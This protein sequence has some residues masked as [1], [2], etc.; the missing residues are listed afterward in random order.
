MTREEAQERIRTRELARLGALFAG[1]AHEIRNPLSTIGL[2][3]QL[4]KEDFAEPESPA[5]KR[6]L[7]RMTVIESEVKRLQSILDEFLGYVRVPDLTRTETDINEL[8]EELV[9][10]V[11][12]EMASKSVSL[13]YFGNSSVGALTVDSDQ[14]RAVFVN[15]LRNALDA[16]D[17]DDEVMVSLRTGTATVDIQITD[18]GHGMT[19][20]VAKKVFTPYFSTKKTGTGLGL[21][22]ARRIVELHGGSLQLNSDPERGTQFSIHL[23]IVTGADGAAVA[24]GTD[25][26]S[27]SDG[28]HL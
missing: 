27:D 16:C 20:E 9:E 10:F 3:L 2:N 15:L 13:R 24:A 17:T 5:E 11:R 19:P 21:P 23:P 25:E 14:L 6:S 28:G 26:P 12:P 8:L 4:V 22:M 1:F 7:R 18:T